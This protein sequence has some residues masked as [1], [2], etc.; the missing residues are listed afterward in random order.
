LLEGYKTFITAAVAALVAGLA[1]FG[2]VDQ[3]TSTELGGILVPL[4][5]IFLRMGVKNESEKA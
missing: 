4:A 2:V 3:A 1:A 5:L